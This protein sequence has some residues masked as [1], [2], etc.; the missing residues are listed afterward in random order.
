MLGIDV[1]V[2]D[3]NIIHS[4]IGDANICELLQIVQDNFCKWQGLLHA[5]GSM[6]NPPKCSWTPFIWHYNNLGHAWLA[7]LPEHTQ[8]QLW[9]TN[10][11]RWSHILWTNKPSDAV[12]LLGVHIT[13][14]G[15]ELS[16]LKQKQQKYVQFLLLTLLSKCEAQVIYKQC[17]LPTVTY[18][19]PATNIS[20]SLIY[21]TQ[22]TITF[23]FL[24]QMGYPWHIPQSIVYAPETLGGLGLCHLGQEQGVQ[25]TL[26][27]LW[28]LW[29]NTTN[30]KL[31]TITINQYQLYA[32]VQ[33][34]I[35]E[36]TKPIPWMPAG[37]IS[38]ICDFLYTTNCKIRLQLPCTPT[39]RQMHDW[40]M[41]GALWMIPWLASWAHTLKPSIVSACIFMCLCCEKF[42]SQMAVNYP[43]AYLK[44]LLTPLAP[45]L[46]GHTNHYLPK[47]HGTYGLMPCGPCMPLSDNL[48]HINW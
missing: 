10:L 9:A 11:T 8:P 26:Q 32:G 5:S 48:R 23:L 47:S 4:N 35:L 24:T 43:P 22:C 14:D 41:I 17:Y 19:F 18:P 34:P 44:E 16:I 25:Q 28:H 37:W 31:Y 45:N 33:Q 40:C 27:L 2:D 6:L 36:D 13:V 21:N 15:K 29:A 3:T 7:Q 39:P 1:F 38:S 42:Q 12:Q 30:G 46:P 20:P